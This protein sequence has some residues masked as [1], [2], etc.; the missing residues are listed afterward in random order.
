VVVAVVVVVVVVMMVARKLRV[1]IGKVVGMGGRSLP[2]RDNK[3]DHHHHHH[4][5]DDSP[6]IGITPSFPP[7]LVTTFF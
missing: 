7:P 4:C 6:P 3:E 5:L 2:E 1:G